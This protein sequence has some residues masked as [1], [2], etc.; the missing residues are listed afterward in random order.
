MS[1]AKRAK[2]ALKMALRAFLIMRVILTPFA[3]SDLNCYRSSVV[4]Y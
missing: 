2:N 4:V 3:F 1:E